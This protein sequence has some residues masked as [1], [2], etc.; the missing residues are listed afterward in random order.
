MRNAVRQVGRGAAGGEQALLRTRARRFSLGSP[1]SS[2][3]GRSPAF[4]ESPNTSHESQISVPLT[5]Q[6]LSSKNIRNS[7]KT[8]DGGASYPSMKKGSV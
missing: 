5:R 3:P 6:W 8:N 7:L 4:H 2:M 1:A